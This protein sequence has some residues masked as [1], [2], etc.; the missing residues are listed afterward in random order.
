MQVFT[1]HVRGHGSYALIGRDPGDTVP[2]LAR[3]VPG[4]FRAHCAH[5]PGYTLQVA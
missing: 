4:S 5:G 1:W 2:E 3:L